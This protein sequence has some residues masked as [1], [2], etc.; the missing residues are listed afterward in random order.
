MPARNGS[1]HVAKIVRRYK[2][3]VYVT[4][5]LRRSY[6]DG[7]KVLHETLGNI[8]HLPERL[9]DLIRR[10][11]RGEEFVS[12]GEAFRTTRSLPYGHVAAVLGMVRKLGLDRLIASKRSRRRDLVTAMIVR[13]DP[14]SLFQAGDHPLVAHH[15]TGRGVG[16][17]GCRRR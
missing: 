10:S 9:I 8:S 7:K 4:H 16:R 14:L 12:A 15:H 11:L 5:L 1:V 3:N 13:A 2:R 6:R 17:R